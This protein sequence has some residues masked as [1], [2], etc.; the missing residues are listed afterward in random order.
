ME[1]LKELLTLVSE[2]E[3]TSPTKMS[4]DYRDYDEWRVNALKLCTRL[5]KKGKLDR[6]SDGYSVVAPGF[7]IV[8][9]WD[10]EDREGWVYD[11]FYL[12]NKMLGVKKK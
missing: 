12:M 2:A 9:S 3:T 8:A 5:D 10:N 6:K 4:V 11:Y 1:T 7:G